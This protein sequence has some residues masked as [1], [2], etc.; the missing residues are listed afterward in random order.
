MSRE[1]GI[2]ASL[3]LIKLLAITDQVNL[4]RCN[5]TDKISS[6]WSHLFEFKKQ[7]ISFNQR[8]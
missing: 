8:T 1:I 3:L 6:I 7:M 5:M 4:K 2:L